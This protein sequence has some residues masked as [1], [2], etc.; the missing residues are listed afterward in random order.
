MTKGKNKD[1][2]VQ[3]DILDLLMA[4]S[5][6]GGAVV[7]LN[8]AL[9]YA[10]SP[11][12]HASATSDGIRRKTSKS[13]LMDAALSLIVTDNLNTDHTKC[14]VIDLIVTIRCIAKVPNTFRKLAFQLL[15]Q[16]P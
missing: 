4:V 1:V 16:I 15:H 11:V 2:A 10:P 14:L 8:K 5:S 9:S 3:R 6:K 13:K 7:D 12:P